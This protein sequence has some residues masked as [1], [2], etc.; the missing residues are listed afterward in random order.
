MCLMGVLWVMGGMLN[1]SKPSKPL[2]YASI[3]ECDTES[4]TF[5]EIFSE[6]A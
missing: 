3:S 5:K 1:L 4:S 2:L 6:V